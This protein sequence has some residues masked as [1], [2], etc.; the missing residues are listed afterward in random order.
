MTLATTIHPTAIIADGAKI[1]DSVEI[2]P[3]AVIGPNVEIKAG[4][5]IG[6]HAVVDGFTTIGEN[7]RIFA[8]ASIGLEPQDI[9][10]KNE[11]TGVVIG[12]RV[13]VREYA[14]IH[15][16]TAD[17]FTKVGDDCFLMAYS[18]IAHDCK[19]GNGVIMANNATLAGHVQVGDRA[20]FGG[21]VMIH[22][23]ARVGRMCM[24]GGITGTRV[25]LPPFTVCDDRPAVVVG[26]NLVGM[27]RG[28][29]GQEVRSVIK[30]AYKLIYGS[31]L[32]NTQALQQIEAELPQFD[33]IK[34][35]VE[36]YR[37][38]KRGV[39]KGSW[40][41]GSEEGEAGADLG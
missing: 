2:A 30:Q 34:E 7:C 22:Q 33:E 26:L 35:I 12:D 23:N 37:S 39:A 16:G 15:R 38:S 6:A 40:G 8:G 25:D 32:N 29:I 1:H 9:S 41:S 31:G 4:T 19:V 21:T 18:H 28:K 11:P 14:T 17:R 3:Y 24:I 10:Y 5:K 13:T 27:R 36:L 20:V